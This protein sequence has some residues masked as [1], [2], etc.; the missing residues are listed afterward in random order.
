MCIFHTKSTEDEW[1]HKYPH[2]LSVLFLII[3]YFVA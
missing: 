2:T 1:I 3:V